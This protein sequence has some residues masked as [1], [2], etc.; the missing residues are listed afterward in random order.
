MRL[1]LA[2]AAALAAS[3]LYSV[4]LAL[5]ALEARLAPREERLRLS[6]LRRLASRPRWLAGTALGLGG[7]GLQ[8]AALALAPL[9]LVQP[10]LALGLVLLLGGGACV[11]GERIGRREVVGVASVAVGLAGVTLTAPERSPS[12]APAAVLIIA[13]AGL[14]ALALAPYALRALAPAPGLLVAAG[15]GVAYACDGLATKLAVDD[16]SASAWAGLLVW[17]P[18]MGLAAGVG[19]L[20]EM[21]ALQTAPA[22]RAA[23]VVA[24]ASTIVPVS[25]APLL[26]GESWT[27]GTPVRAA[28]ALSLLAVAVGVFLLARSSAVLAVL[29]AKATSADTD[30]ACRPRVASTVSSRPSV[31]AAAG[32]A[33]S[34]TS[35]ISPA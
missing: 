24:V 27:M 25:L 13:L 35:T 6:L 30:T 9:T 11:L 20:S 32:E 15:A 2:L 33:S 4:G 10:L 31:A 7:W 5:Q 17:L 14:A 29:S 16:V 18:A 21:S 3:S 19:T 26:T 22:T 1:T 34:V 12:H 8:A 23:P 28:L